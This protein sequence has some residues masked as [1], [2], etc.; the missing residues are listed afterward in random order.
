[1]PANNVLTH[2]KKRKALE[3]IQAQQ[4]SQAKDLLLEVCQSDRHDPESWFLLGNIASALGD[5]AGAEQHLRQALALA[6]DLPQISYNLGNVLRLQRRF[7]EAAGA[8]RRAIQLKP[9][10]ALAHANLGASLHDIGRISESVSANREAIHLA[11]GLLPAHLNLGQC[12]IKLGQLDEAYAAFRSAA[13]IKPNNTDVSL[14][15]AR[16]QLGQNRVD[17]AVETLNAALSRAPQDARILSL[18][19][20]TYVRNDTPDKV[21]ELAQRAIQSRP[22]SGLDRLLLCETL[23]HVGRYDDAVRAYKDLLV[24]DPDFRHARLQLG[25]LHL[26]LGHWD[27]GWSLYRVRGTDEARI[28]PPVEPEAFV[29][30]KSIFV[31]EEQGLGDELF[32]LRF[33]AAPAMQDKQIVYCT[34]PKLAALLSRCVSRIAVTT[35]RVLPEGMEFAID[36]GDLPYLTQMQRTVDVPPPLALTPRPDRVAS[37]RSLLASLAGTLD[38]QGISKSAPIEQLASV[39]R[40][41]EASIVMVQRHP[42]DLELEIFRRSLGRPAHD[43]SEMNEDL[44]QIV[45]LLSLLDEY[46]GVS[47]TNMHLRAGLGQTARVLVPNPPEWRWMASGDESPWFPGFRVYRQGTDMDWTA[48]L[49]KLADDLAAAFST[50]A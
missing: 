40:D 29:A 45:A 13:K 3:Y 26:L 49:D 47:N 41:R 39:L 12:L 1:M 31:A 48:A 20:H 37:I 15:L 8:F 32:F 4:F 2:T 16:C 10:Y 35:K 50:R 28:S 25:G 23:N 7:E 42:T 21:I 9:D 30:A 19:A 43:L 34:K 46:V 27:Q 24:L 11:P 22:K 36:V 5:Q 6:P 14:G 44:E 17:E 18:L 33:L 38:V